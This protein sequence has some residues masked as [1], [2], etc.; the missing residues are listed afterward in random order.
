MELALLA[1]VVRV[2]EWWHA[3][4]A[5]YQALPAKPRYPLESTD[6]SS[7]GALFPFQLPAASPALLRG[8]GKRMAK[9]VLRLARQL[10]LREV[11]Q[12]SHDVLSNQ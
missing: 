6:S 9:T 5:A 7:G 1:Q 2:C 12:Q 3:D 11:Y 4:E 8:V 10:V